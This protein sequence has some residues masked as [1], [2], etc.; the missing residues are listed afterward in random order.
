MLFFLHL[1]CASDW[2][3]WKELQLQ[4]RCCCTSLNRWSLV[5]P[6]KCY[7]LCLDGKNFSCDFQVKL[8]LHVK[9]AFFLSISV[10]EL[11][12]KSFMQRNN[13]NAEMFQM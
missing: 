13:V 9:N 2:E 5:P 3:K 1:G 4:P 12:N 6:A 8:S 11:G 10:W 7:S